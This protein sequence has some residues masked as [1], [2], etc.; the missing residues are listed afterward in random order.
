M[1][2]LFTGSF[3]CLEIKRD[4]SI[5]SIYFFGNFFVPYLG[6]ENG[7]RTTHTVGTVCVEMQEFSYNKVSFTY[8]TF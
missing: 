7:T 4:Q 8:L 5:K 6:I 1:F 2:F 3:W